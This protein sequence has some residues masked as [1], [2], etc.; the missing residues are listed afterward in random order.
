MKHLLTLLVVISFT[1]FSPLSAQLPDGTVAPNW[2]LTDIN[3]NTHTLYNLLNQGKMVVI[4]FSATW[5]G[6]CWNYMQSGALETFW[7]AHGPNGANDAQVFYIES[8]WSTG[9][10]DLLGLT[11][12]SQGNWVA[13]IDFP[14]IDLAPGNNTANNY[15]INYYPTLYAVCSDHTLYELGQVPAS[16]WASFIT[17]CGMEA[18]PDGIQPALCAGQ[19]S[20]TVEATGGNLPY[21]YNWSN[22]GSTQTISGLSAGTYHVTVTEA[23][24]KMS[25]VDF[26]VPGATSTVSVSGLS[27]QPVLCSGSSTGNINLNVNGGTPGYQYEWSNGSSSQDLHNVPAGSYTLTITDNNDCVLI[28]TYSV[29]EPNE[30]EADAEITPDNCDQEDGTIILDIAGGVGNYEVSSSEGDVF[31]NMIVNLPAGSVEVEI[32]D[33]NGC[34]W[35]QEFEIPVA[36]APTV[37]LIQG[38]QLSCTQLTTQITGYPSGG[39]GEFTYHWTTANGHMASNAN[40]ATIT[41]DQPGTYTLMVT[42]V[43]SGCITAESQVVNANIILPAV[44]AGENQGVDC[45]IHQVTLQGSGDPLNTITWSTSNGHILSGGNTYQPVVDQPGTYIVTVVNS[46]TN[47]PNHDTVVVVNNQ[48]PAVAAFQYLSA[49]LSIN[50][51]NAST[52]SNVGGWSW[53][54]GDGATSSEVNAVHTYAAPG[55]YEVCLSVENGCGV[56]QTCQS[57]EVTFSG[58]VILVDEEITHVLCHGASTGGIT[59][60]VNG[61]SGVYTYLWTNADTTFTTSSI[62]GVPAGN[63]QLVLTDDSGNVFI[64]EYTIL[65]PGSLQVNGSSVV[66]NQCFGETNGSITLDVIGG[67]GPYL[68]SWNGSALQPQN[69]INQLPGGIVEAT[70]VDSNGCLLAAGLF[71]IIEPE[72]LVVADSIHSLRCHGDS[73][74]SINVT[75]FGGTAPYLYAWENG[76]QETSLTGL[77]GGNYL[78]TVTDAH[79]CLTAY[80]AVIQEPSLIGISNVNITNASASNQQDGSITLDPSGG[81]APYQISWSNGQT[82]NTINNLAPGNYSFVITDANGC[83]FAAP[84]PIVVS[85]S[86]SIQESAWPDYISIAPNP[87]HGD[88]KVKWTSIPSSN[89]TLSIMGVDGKMLASQKMTTSGQWNLAPLGLKEGLY[90]ILLNQDNHIYPFKLIIL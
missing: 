82:G 51:M 79:G 37:D 89:A 40:A 75:A 4:E 14:L 76:S 52:G 16:V 5:C 78:L 54:F 81:T 48:L 45:D 90:I 24:G 36:D 21:S 68:Y 12:A 30:L 17:S 59:L 87:A 84:D 44:N 65:E 22:G 18:H 9:M 74:G 32:T 1:T 64:D 19:G 50:V 29:T 27:I 34:V 3:G 2:T 61:G 33:D 35:T 25:V 73:D 72:E 47:C 39:Y 10:N 43:F 62:S 58:S 77:T 38:P 70:V 60:N 23:Y 86:T 53:T 6:P 85:V 66:D 57:V 28:Q 55:T 83:S 67:V 69:F 49:G 7:N 56:D 26:V 8:D 80:T 31:G 13:N 71:T 63:Y 88:V 42:D 20:A 11:P 41:V 15:D 46:V